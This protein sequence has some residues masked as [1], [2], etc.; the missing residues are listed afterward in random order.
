MGWNWYKTETL[1]GGEAQRGPDALGRGLSTLAVAFP[2]ITLLSP[3]FGI[4]NCTTV[5][6][7][8][9]IILLSKYPS[10]HRSESR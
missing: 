5:Y 9:P 10:T 7:H 8:T 1:T 2:S 6:T 3:H 4:L